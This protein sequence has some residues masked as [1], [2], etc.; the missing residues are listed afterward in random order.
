M[1]FLPTVPNPNHQALIVFLTICCGAFVVMALDMFL[2]AP[3]LRRWMEARRL[4]AVVRSRRE[5]VRRRR[6]PAGGNS[7]RR[8]KR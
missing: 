3:L 5:R 8:W 2:V 4:R 6:R 1:I 7:A